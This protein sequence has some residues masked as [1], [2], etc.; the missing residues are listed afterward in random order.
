MKIR[1]NIFAACCIFAITYNDDVVGQEEEGDWETV[2]PSEEETVPTTNPL[3][4][5]EPTCFDYT[6]VLDLSP[7]EC[8]QHSLFNK[9]RDAYDLQRQ[10]EGAEHCKG[11]VDKEI[12]AMTGTTD[13]LSSRNALQALCDDAHKS[14]TEEIPDNS[15]EFLENEPHV[16]NV[17]EFMK[18]E[19]FLNKESGNLWQEE[20][21]FRKRGGYDR[22]AYIGK[23]P[24]KNDYMRTTD[25]SYFG[26]E[27][28]KKF[29]MNEAGKTFLSVPSSNFESGCPATNAGLCCW[30]R[31]R[32]YFD[33]NGNCHFA[34]CE[35]TG[36]DPGDNTDLCFTENESG[37]F[38]YPSD[39]TEGNLHCHGFAWSDNVDYSHDVNVK[40]KWNNLFFVSMYDHLYQRGYVES[41]TDNPKVVGEQAM[42]GCV[43]DMY[44]IARADCTEI[45]GRTNYTAYQDSE[46][47]LFVVK[48]KS[49][50]YKLQFKACEGY[51][52]VD[53]LDSET[54]LDFFEGNHHKAGLRR[55]NND[56]SAF[57]F[58]QYLEG[59]ISKER[60][61]KLEE[62]IIGYRDPT[63][64]DG[65]KEREVACKAAFEKRYPDMEWM[66]RKFELE[67]EMA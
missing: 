31:D 13:W 53:E 25:K 62:T 28:I 50:T 48:H 40:A 33:N 22:Y 58:R 52:Y 45:I 56:L 18:G 63:V 67:A 19:G 17:E 46:T 26:G 14:A 35:K 66:E 49:D 20:E 12:R 43:E 6:G 32:Q 2:P 11:G 29:Y 4:A 27:G 57:V 7:T 55:Q 39:E 44:P 36:S 9:I 61:E 5:L 54:Y 30:S 24:R 37:V 10:T 1:I 8:T 42:C 51:D 59:K 15:W 41:I 23:D 21:E 38:P 60:T 3:V 47:G 64:N 65:D 16:I 34:N